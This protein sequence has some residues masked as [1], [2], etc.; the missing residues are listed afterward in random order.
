MS[1]VLNILVA[2]QADKA[3]AGFDNLISKFTNDS[4]IA[5]IGKSF[6]AGVT[7]PIIGALSYAT[8]EAVKFNSAINSTVRTL[9]LT[10]DEAAALSKEVLTLAPSLGLLPEEFAAVAAEAGKMG[11]AKEDV[12]NFGKTLA[13]LATIAD[14]PIDQFVKLGGSIKTVFDLSTEQF[15]KFGAAVNSLDDKIG[16]TT[17][18]ILDFTSRVG[19]IGKTIGFTSEQIAT[20][21]SVYQKLG[22]ESSAAET[23][24]KNLLQGLFTIQTA[25]PKAK[26]ALESLGFSAEEFGRQMAADPIGMTLKFLD[27]LNAVEDAADR[28][29]KL[30]LIAGNNGISANSALAGSTDLLREALAVAADESENM[31]KKMREFAGKM[32]DPAI[33]GKV[34]AAQMN[35]LSIQFGMVLIPVLSQVLETIT[36]VIAKFGEFLT[37]NPGFAKFFVIAATG[38]AIIPPLMI[39]IGGVV[40]AI[41]TI[42]G[43]ITPVIAALGSAWA[44]VSSLGGVFSTLGII[45]TSGG[46]AAVI[47]AILSLGGLLIPLVGV[48]GIVGAAIGGLIFNTEDLGQATLGMRDKFFSIVKDFPK[49]WGEVPGYFKRIF[50]VIIESAQSFILDFFVS[51]YWGENQLINAIGGFLDKLP[52]ILA[53]GLVFAVKVV[54]QIL[55]HLPGVVLKILDY[56][57]MGTN[58]FL[59][60]LARQCE[61]GF[62]EAITIAVRILW[63][64][65][66]KMVEAFTGALVAVY[67]FGSS[68]AAGLYN[69]IVGAFQSIPDL[70]SQFGSMF[71]NA[72]LGLINS[73]T[74]GI[75]NSA[76]S[77][78]SSVAG[79]MDNV[80]AYLPFSPA[81]VG[82]LSDLD[83]SG[84]AF[85]RTFA[86]NFD[87]GYMLSKVDQ[88]LNAI[89]PQFSASSPTEGLTP[90][91]AGGGATGSVIINFEQVVN[92][93]AKVNSADVINAIKSSQREFLKILDQAQTY[94]NRRQS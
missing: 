56:V 59:N 4:K 7:V 82:A 73:F 15:D 43:I 52:E 38:V 23:G 63:D 30:V 50:E 58:D 40:T 77:L 31:N 54:G 61:W 36:P 66:G 2:L 87:V 27:A 68:L 6:T 78:Y 62:L 93:D 20:F 65:P 42:G 81:K 90:V 10:K 71:Y 84:E 35:A 16:G 75:V 91:A 47:P 55:W 76:Q 64:L 89:T 39:A 51:W 9:D 37:V 29:S 19:A 67:N 79:V 49:T 46:A 80:R 32:K 26:G 60:E 25:S 5:N 45:L 1:D 57:I 3:I 28:Q 88:G 94:I 34:L 85:F 17:P 18:N 44:V 22:F 92:I 33:Q 41:T 72:G 74:S 8:S 13:E 83:T 21:G 48:L 12:A 24:F 14:T 53:Q 11:V 86:D 69:A 70:L